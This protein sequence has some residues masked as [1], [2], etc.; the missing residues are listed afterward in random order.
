MERHRVRNRDIS[1]QYANNLLEDYTQSTI[2]VAGA[3]STGAGVSSRGAG[4]PGSETQDLTRNRNVSSGDGTLP[5][6]EA[7]SVILIITI[8]VIIIIIII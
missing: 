3:S 5:L 6:Q 8:V 7:C 4:T 2:I 1:Q